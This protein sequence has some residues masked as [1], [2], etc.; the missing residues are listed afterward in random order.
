MP[1]NNKE[2]I[3]NNAEK[4]R[5]ALRTFGA[6][7]AEYVKTKKLS[8]VDLAAMKE[9]AKEK[10]VFVLPTGPPVPF[11]KKGVFITIII[12]LLL[13]TGG[14][15]YYFYFFKNRPEPQSIQPLSPPSPLLSSQQ[16]KIIYTTGQADLKNQL[17][18]A[19]EETYTPGD[20]VYL[21]IK[22]EKEENAVYLSSTSFLKF[23]GA[24]TSSQLTAFI[25]ENF[26]LGIL[27]TDKKHPIII[28]EIKKGSYETAYAGMLQ[29]EN[30][31]L[32]D[33]SFFFLQKD[34]EKTNTKF[35]DDL[36]KNHV[37]RIAENEKGSIL[38]YVVLNRKYIIITDTTGSLEE[39]IKRFEIY[40]FS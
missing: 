4:K 1:E 3:D 17:K 8:L 16:E 5:H 13:A 39:L 9:R 19:L 33:L 29:W 7:T 31:I 14:A 36:V 23:V 11:Y 25:E 20:S 32:K 2:T 37:V 24:E 6:D 15:G 26:L 10:Q 28:F 18:A 22:L 38:L 12:V 30:S 35:K 40:K 34:A 21:P 27:N